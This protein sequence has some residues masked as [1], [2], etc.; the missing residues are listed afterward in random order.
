MLF[1]NFVLI[2]QEQKEKRSDV[3][4]RTYLT[5]HLVIFLTIFKTWLKYFFIYSKVITY[6]LIIKMINVFFF[7]NKEKNLCPSPPIFLIVNRLKLNEHYYI[8]CFYEFDYFRYLINVESY[9]FISFS[10]WLISLS[11][12]S[13]SFI[14]I[15]TDVQ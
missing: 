13:S 10:N 11:I 9:N 14:D 5:Q 1:V 8:L 6:T 12:T 7:Q 2:K 15:T 3:P 4:K